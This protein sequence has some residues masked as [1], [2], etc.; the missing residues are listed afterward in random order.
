MRTA[1][2]LAE[3][4][5]GRLVIGRDPLD[6]IGGVGGIDIEAEDRDA[7]V[8]G[9]VEDEP[10]GIHPWV[11]G[12]DPGEERRRVMGLEPRRVIGRQG[13]R[14]RM[15]LAETKRCECDQHLPHPFDRREVI[16]AGPGRGVKPSADVGLSIG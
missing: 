5:R 3:D 16:A 15:R 7:E 6:A 1:W 2:T 14:R 8:A 11:V 10:L 4:L 13:E 12:Q 9:V